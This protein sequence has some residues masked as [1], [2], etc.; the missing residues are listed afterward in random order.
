[1]SSID[2][3]IE[4]SREP[5]EFRE[6]R[7][8][9][10]ARGQAIQKLRKFALVDPHYYILEL[11]QSAV[12][13]GATYID[14][15][16]GSDGMALSYIGGHFT[17]N[18]LAQL[19]DFLF[20]S[21]DDVEHGPLRQLA[22]GV[23]ALMLFDPEEIVVETGNGT[24]P[25]TSRIA[26]RG[27]ED[28]VEVGRPDKALEG[29]FIRANGLDRKAMKK[30][31]S[32]DS[33][34]G[35]PR[36]YTAVEDRCL[37]APVP[38]LFNQDPVFGYSSQRTPK[39]LFGF[40]KTVSFD[41]GDLYG[42]I[43]IARRHSGSV[44]R[45][46]THGVWIESTRHEFPGKGDSPVTNLGGVV[47][48]DRLRK[49]ADHSAIVED[50]RYQEMWLRLRPYV[51][52]LVAGDIDN[53]GYDVWTLDGQ[54]LENRELLDILRG[55][56]S[57]VLIPEDAVD[58]E[59]YAESARKIG[60]SLAMPVLGVSAEDREVVETL[61]GR[62]VDFVTPDLDD[63]RELH[64]YTGNEAPLPSRPWL[65]APVELGSSSLVDVAKRLPAPQASV[66]IQPRLS[67]DTVLDEVS[68]GA[69]R[70]AAWIL[71]ESPSKGQPLDEWKSK[72][73]DT[74]SESIS[75]A[76]YTPETR[77]GDDYGINVEVRNAGRVVWKG[78]LEAVAPGQVL[79]IEVAD[80]APRRL[81]NPP[82]GGDKPVAEMLASAVV[83]SHLNALEDA[84]DRGLQAALRADV[85]PNT[86]AARLTLSS[87]VHRVVKRITSDGGQ[88]GVRFS[89]VDP[90][91]DVEILEIPILRTLSG[92]DVSLR[93]L[94]RMLGDCH[95][96]VYAVRAD[97]AA[98]LEE[99]DR[100]RILVVDEVV[101]RLLVALVG[102][103][104]YVRVD[105]RDVVVEYGQFQCRDIAVG[106]RDYPQ[107]PLLVEGGDVESLDDKKRRDVIN[108]LV[109][110][111]VDVAESDAPDAEAQELR[112]HAWRHL[113]WFAAHR[114]DYAVA[115]AAGEQVD[116]L[117]LFA[118]SQQRTCG[119]GDIR[120]AIEDRG[121]VEMLDG[122]AM[123]AGEQSFLD[124]V[125]RQI[126]SYDD[127]DGDFI[128]DMNPFVLHLL[129]GVVQG[130]ADYH[131]S[132]QE[133]DALDRRHG[134]RD[135]MLE[136]VD[137]DNDYARG[138]MG[139]PQNPVDNPAIVVFSGTTQQAVL[140][141]D[142]G[143]QFGVI[144]KVRLRQGIDVDD[145]EG[146]LADIARDVLS[147]LLARLPGLASGDDADRY[148]RALSALLEYASNQVQ[149]VG[150]R[151][152]TVDSEV[153]DVL[154]REILNVPLFPGPD[155]LPTSAMAL[156]RDFQDQVGTA[157]ARRQDVQYR[158]RIADDQCP[159]A[160][161]E[162]LDSEMTVEHIH[163][164]GH[165]AE[166]QAI[167][168][169]PG[170]DADPTIRCATRT[171]EYWI[172]ALHPDMEP[173]DDC[174]LHIE[175]A[176]DGD[177]FD[178]EKGDEYCHLVVQSSDPNRPLLCINPD[179]W[180]T[181]WMMGSGDD[182]ERSI[183]WAILGACS[184][185]N[186]VL[187]E[188]TNEHELICQRRVAEA[189]RDGRLAMIRSETNGERP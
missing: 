179:H 44:F 163:R 22:L 61:G 91:L 185:I 184:R 120:R 87:L 30:R 20:A 138:T 89:V 152:L 94:E 9:S 150:R 100:D 27:G 48:F 13:N 25:G 133:I 146:M 19:F 79:I 99:L 182:S 43:G 115:E 178:G 125:D 53:V 107:F 80:M 67:D 17:E 36:E 111:L 59:Q 109:S 172:N 116:E 97:I 106:L 126:A 103:T 16:C 117:P 85:G 69:L 10:I 161:M 135:A 144:G 132:Q 23:N 24:L 58:D 168:S 158:P 130:T 34:G 7:E 181:R 26:I 188:V 177:Y 129:G 166:L 155:G 113:Q 86:N 110:K 170:A 74:R 189:L 157:L 134:D 104:A 14:I 2:H 141:Q 46:L 145:V 162:W 124:A 187:D 149:L 88:T 54:H 62:D 49:T 151:D 136:S 51:N 156:Y 123:G 72:H 137:V 167:E 148:N 114:S 45:L 142:L 175:V 65:I 41:E 122:W 84:A 153:R 71:G 119:F 102:P 31:S 37:V 15:K 66:P 128:L 96:L 143:Q 95:G 171:L 78:N 169:G 8:F 39:S 42:T 118:L 83:D 180:M 77:S 32:L 68:T 174:R 12:A 56:D 70:K 64:F 98:D 3:V 47:T 176:A 35:K 29:T 121:T 93:D 60:E 73:L 140:R 139:I 112:R 173:G 28:T 40:H 33:H 159:P 183:A 160:L 50:E 154:A 4:R 147:H 5:G 57:V 18:A 21:E 165:T 127:V 82:A 92:N 81:W 131:L 76:V 55:S 101:E 75:A 52:K 108:M 186:R 1:M 90:D 6:R 38:I 11:I 164:P 63:E 105:E